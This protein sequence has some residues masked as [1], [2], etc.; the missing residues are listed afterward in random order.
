[1]TS[2]LVSIFRIWLPYG[3]PTPVSIFLLP[4][5]YYGGMPELPEVE[6]LKRTLEPTLIGAVVMDVAVHRRDVIR[7]TGGGR[8]SGIKSTLLNQHRI[9][10]LERHGK[11]LAIVSDSGGAICIHLGMSGQ[12]WL[13]D[14]ASTCNENHNGHPMSHIHCR[15]R[16]NTG[17]GEQE[18]LFRD[19]R[20]FGGIWTYPSFEAVLKER[21][22]LLGPDA[23]S[24]T[25]AKLRM[26]LCRTR[27]PVKAALLDQ[28]LIA[29]VGNIYADEALFVARIHPMNAADTLTDDQ[30]TRLAHAIRSTLRQAIKNGGST[31]R[32]YRD[33]A[34]RKG[35][36]QTYHSVYGR[37]AEPCIRC[38]GRLISQLIGQRTTVFCPQ[39]QSGSQK[40]PSLH[41]RES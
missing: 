29:G 12:C 23:L 35:S 22:A 34:G 26:R 24:V 16:I 27:R 17:R 4:A 28:R 41:E 37:A 40:L 14:P 36:H 15:W 13:R 30:F 1:V 2:P 31:L 5:D 11:Q 25:A 18:L 9:D 8:R 7:R 32:D 20:R 21:W 39:C 3:F 38:D 10:R 6:H 33:G 19:P